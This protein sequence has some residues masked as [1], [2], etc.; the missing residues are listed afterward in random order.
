[1]DREASESQELAGTTTRK[2]FSLKYRTQSYLNKTKFMYVAALFKIFFKKGWHV[3]D[4]N[5]FSSQSGKKLKSAAKHEGKRRFLLDEKTF[6][7][8]LE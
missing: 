3:K 5:S 6:V 4:T 8:T 7:R 2:T 1:M